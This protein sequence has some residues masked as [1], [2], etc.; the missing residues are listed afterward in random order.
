MDIA[1]NNGYY[2]IC[3]CLIEANANIDAKNY[4]GKTLLMIQSS[5]G[6]LHR[7]KHLLKMK[8][9][10]GISDKSGMTA[11]DWAIHNNSPKSSIVQYFSKQYHNVLVK[12]LI[13]DVVA[14]VMAYCGM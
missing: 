11:I 8:A 2:N 9:N 14:M 7:V 5:K 1:L 13:S 6:L 10:L 12:H 4:E 3:C